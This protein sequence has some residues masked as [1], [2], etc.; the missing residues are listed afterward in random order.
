MKY[1]L[2]ICADQDL[3]LTAEEQANLLAKYYV[4]TAAEAASR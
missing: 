4:C 1:L 3:E 2:L